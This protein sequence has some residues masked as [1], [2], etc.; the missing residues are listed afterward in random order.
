LRPGTGGT[1]AAPER[2]IS[3]E[4]KDV[5]YSVVQTIGTARWKWT[6]EIESGRTRSGNY[7][8]DGIAKPNALS[9]KQSG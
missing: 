5:Q 3:V 9:I 8:F 1:F 6:I 4:C 2:F 7:S